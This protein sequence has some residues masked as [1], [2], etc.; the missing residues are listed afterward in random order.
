MTTEDFNIWAASQKKLPRPPTD[1]ELAAFR[2]FL[3]APPSDVWRH[4]KR[5]GAFYIKPF[6]H[7]RV[8]IFWFVLGDAVN[9]LTS[10]NDKLA[11]LVLKLQC[12]PDG[13]GVLGPEPWWSDLP[14]FNN[15]WSEW[16]Q[17]QFDDLPMSS[18]D[19]EINRQANINRNAFLA[20]ITANMGKVMVLDQRQRG[21]H[22]LKQA[23]ERTPISE[24]AILATEPWITY[25]ADTIYD[26]SLQGG[27]MSYEHPHNG[28]NWGVQKGW[29]KARWQYWKKRFQEI[30]TA[31]L[32]EEVRRL[33]KGCAERMDT[34]EKA[35]G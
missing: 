34:V 7:S 17:F 13:K 11:G 26:R 30:S 33:A 29:S 1:K 22:T 8:D 35:K 25:C 31:K 28:T 9:N 16:M 24:A 32:S 6:A 21:G 20:K 3:D 2:E 14:Y 27:L 18:R 19:F 4:A 12:L 5:I 10:Q 15:F 23:L